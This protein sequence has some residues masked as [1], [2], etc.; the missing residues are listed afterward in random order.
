MDQNLLSLV[1]QGKYFGSDGVL[2]YFPRTMQD[3]IKSDLPHG[4]HDSSIHY[5]SVLCSVMTSAIGGS[6]FK[7]LRVSDLPTHEHKW[8]LFQSLHVFRLAIR[9]NLWADD[10]RSWA[11]YF[12]I[13]LD[14]GDHYTLMLVAARSLQ[15]VKR[16]RLLSHMTHVTEKLE[17]DIRRAYQA[18]SK[19]A[20]K[21][22]T[23]GKSYWSFDLG[24][25]EE[26]QLLAQV[27]LYALH[28]E[29]IYL[30]KGLDFGH[31]KEYTL[32]YVI[33]HEKSP[34]NEK[35][36]FIRSLLQVMGCHAKMM[37]IP[38]RVKSLSQEVLTEV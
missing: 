8:S 29:G 15:M 10:V 18:I 31:V 24:Y 33:H 30:Y 16:L 19:I 17:K 23:K 20:E 7:R 28:Q 4:I 14:V 6:M 21:E 35:A 13:R 32:R 12:D 3:Q 38:Y 36:I 1:N 22:N 2:S 5:M 9:A 11:S 27:L 34:D 37:A 25:A 26:V